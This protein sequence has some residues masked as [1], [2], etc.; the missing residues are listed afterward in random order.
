VSGFESKSFDEGYNFKLEWRLLKCRGCDEVF[1]L[2]RNIDYED[3]ILIND[4]LSDEDGY[5]PSV[6]DAYW[7][8]LAKR[9][10]PLW[11]VPF[12]MNDEIERALKETYGALESDLPMLAAVGARSC[13]D[14][15][16]VQL[17]AD[18]ADD[19][20]GKLK[21]LLENGKISEADEL[22]LQ[23][24]TDAGSA[25][26]HRGWYPTTRQL[27]TIMDVLEHFIEANFVKAAVL[28]KLDAESAALGQ[29]IPPRPKRVRKKLR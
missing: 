28:K 18:P 7:P 5:L 6:S 2:K 1:F 25:S 21:T 26:I 10:R 20:S 15:A 13:F 11:L 27:T 3:M 12:S 22:R 14:I 4:P 24:L 19:L 29:K 16:S 9:E 8:P 17:G 23:V